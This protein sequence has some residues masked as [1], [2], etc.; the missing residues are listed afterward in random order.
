MKHKI[1]MAY[2]DFA[3]I[4]NEIVEPLPP[5]VGWAIIGIFFTYLLLKDQEMESRS[6]IIFVIGPMI[7]FLATII[8][9]AVA[10]H[11]LVVEDSLNQI[12]SIVKKSILL[13]IAL[14]V[15]I[16]FTY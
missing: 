12:Q 1:L 15:L 3:I 13:L 4:W 9:A 14:L 5:F 11:N 10:F 7:G 6:I 8:W 16:Y 2:N